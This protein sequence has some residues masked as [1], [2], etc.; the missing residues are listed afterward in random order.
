MKYDISHYHSPLTYF[1]RSRKVSILTNV[2]IKPFFCPQIKLTR[3]KTVDKHGSVYQ[4]TQVTS[5]TLFEVRVYF[6]GQVDSKEKQSVKRNCR[7]W[8]KRWR[9]YL[10]SYNEGDFI[11]LVLRHPE[12]TTAFSSTFTGYQQAQTELNLGM[13]YDCHQSLTL[14]KH[15]TS[16]ITNRPSDFYE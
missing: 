15:A 13:L 1:T 2:V 5:G 10:D 4:A 11:F 16:K 14:S 12:S 6:F 9:R 7:E 3:K 8:K